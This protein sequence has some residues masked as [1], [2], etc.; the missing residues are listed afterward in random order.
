MEYR[1]SIEELAFALGHLG[2]ADVA[3]GFIAST[4]GDLAEAEVKARLVAACHSLAARGLL[5][6]N[7][8]QANATLEP[9]FAAVAGALVQSQ[10]L[11]RC[12]VVSQ[13]DDQLI[14]FFLGRAREVGWVE[15]RV[16][17]GVIAVLTCLNGQ[18]DDD[19]LAGLTERVLHWVPNR[20]SHGD[21][22]S[23]SLGQISSE[24]LKRLRDNSQPQAE[25]VMTLMQ[26]G[27]TD[28]TAQAVLACVAGASVR[29]SLVSI[30]SSQDGN[31]VSNQGILFAAQ[32]HSDDSHDAA[33]YFALQTTQPNLPPIVEVHWG[34][35]EGLM[36]LLRELAT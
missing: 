29:G 5:Q 1:L 3:T 17:S 27:F 14:T 11:L 36:I 20:S 34:T 2:G 33:V 19:A 21:L 4:L 6:A 25:L 15:S 30:S 13:H 24:T 31:L 35:R 32:A 10:R 28:S 8:Q 16:E 18:N 22:P 26:H 23:G 12:N 9:T 7:M